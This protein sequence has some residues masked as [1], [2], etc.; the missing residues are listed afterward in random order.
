MDLV[1]ARPW[2]FIKDSGNERPSDDHILPTFPKSESLLFRT[3]ISKAI[4]IRRRTLRQFL[5]K[6]VFAAIAKASS[7]GGKRGLEF[8]ELLRAK[9]S[10]GYVWGSRRRK[11]DCLA[12]E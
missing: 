8:I 11:R 4:G 9:W 1:I 6:I 2:V 7:A 12:K 10:E 3:S 5:S